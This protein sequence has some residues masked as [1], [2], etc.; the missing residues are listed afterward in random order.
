MITSHES[1]TLKNGKYNAMVTSVEVTANGFYD[2]DKPEDG[3]NSPS[4]LTVV[5]R[6]ENGMD[7]TQKFVRPAE[8]SLFGDLCRINDIDPVGDV[9]EQE[10]VGTECVVEVRDN[11]NGYATIYNAY[12]PAED[13]TEKKEKPTSKKKA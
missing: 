3:W 10:L 1:T 7:F 13:S 12:K 4:Q 6:I 9:D 5:F 2:P 11:K 8:D